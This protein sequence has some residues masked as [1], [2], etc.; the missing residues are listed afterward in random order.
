MTEIKTEIP[1]I[2]KQ[3]KAV[4]LKGPNKGRIRNPLVAQEEAI[5]ILESAGYVSPD[6][7]YLKRNAIK[8]LDARSHDYILTSQAS[9]T[10]D[11]RKLVEIDDLTKVLNKKGISRR[12]EEAVEQ[13]NRLGTSYAVLVMDVDKF[14]DFNDTY[15]HLEGDEVLIGFAQYMGKHTRK[16]E[17]FG[18]Y[19]G[20]E[21][22]DLL[23]NPSRDSANEIMKRA[24]Q[25]FTEKTAEDIRYKNLCVSLG[26]AHLERGEKLDAE[27]LLNRADAAMYQAKKTPG[28][29]L[30]E[31]RYNMTETDKNRTS[32]K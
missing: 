15:G 31:W 32:P 27:T 7:Y 20:D 19:G 28:T 11:T 29:S 17:G 25:F 3:S 9:K 18:R 26:V 1:Q 2:L 5:T 21:F 22:V 30:V 4:L 6:N 12:V 14:K 8:E 13:H 16:Y 10:E 23:E 24:K